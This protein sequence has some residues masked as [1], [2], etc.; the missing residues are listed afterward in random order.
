MYIAIWTVISIITVI[1]VILGL[2]DENRQFRECNVPIEAE[3]IDVK[4]ERNSGTSD[5]W[6]DGHSSRSYSYDIY[7][8]VVAYRYEGEDYIIKIDL[9]NTE[10]KR[11]IVGDTVVIQ[12]NPDDPS[13]YNFKTSENWQ[14]D[15]LTNEELLSKG[16]ENNKSL[17][18][19]AIVAGIFLVPLFLLFLFF[20]IIVLKGFI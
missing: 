12:I 9:D 13:E 5:R 8:P 1:L 7:V 14:Y 10:P 4:K 18:G 15:Y 17:I 2:K 6:A 20:G 11:F 19:I 16:L 3:I